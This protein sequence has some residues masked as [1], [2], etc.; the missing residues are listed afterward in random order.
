MTHRRGTGL[1]LHRIGR[2]TSCVR[3]VY[4]KS[5]NGSRSECG[6]EVRTGFARIHLCKIGLSPIGRNLD[7]IVAAVLCTAAVIAQVSTASAQYYPLGGYY[8]YGS[9][10]GFYNRLGR[11]ISV[12]TTHATSPWVMSNLILLRN[13]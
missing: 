7:E 2:A 4:W 5:G 6:T 3:Q 12:G 10:E 1:G 11:K 8:E 13:A 9:P